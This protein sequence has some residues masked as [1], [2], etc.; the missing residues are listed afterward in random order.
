MV[1]NA[2]TNEANGTYSVN[3]TFNGASVYKHTVNNFSIYKNDIN[4]EWLI[5]SGEPPFANCFT[6]IDFKTG[7]SGAATPPLGLWDFGSSVSMALPVALTEFK[8]MLLSSRFVQLF[9]QTAAEF[10][11]DRF[12]IERS[13]N[14][15][16]YVQIGQLRGYGTT[17]QTQDYYFTDQFPTD[18]LNY[19]RL[20]Q[21]DFDG[22]FEFSE[23]ISIRA[24]LGGNPNLSIYP[25]PTAER[26]IHLVIPMEKN[27]SVT[28]H[29]Y[30][31]VGRRVF[32]QNLPTAVSGQIISN[33]LSNLP[34]GTYQVQ[35]QISNTV[36]FEKLILK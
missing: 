14:G 18:G 19:Y 32:Q 24:N 22:R 5:C 31:F 21:V 7:S 26:T 34:A 28:I 25:N 16:D 8:G 15:V 4:D 17:S 30:D 6:V 11:N 36:F 10:E 27:S 35:V 23:V 33:N 3:G 1:S 29:V 12:D 13:Q 9:W 2:T 20:K